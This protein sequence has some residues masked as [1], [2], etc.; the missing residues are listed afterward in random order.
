M[1]PIVRMLSLDSKKILLISPEA[2]GINHVSKH[3]YAKE[4]AKLGNEVYFLNPPSA[5]F[6]LT[7]I[8]KGLFV[9]DYKS[10]FRGLSKLPHFLSAL[11]IKYQIQKIEKKL[12]VNVEIIWNFDSSRFFNLSMLTQKLRICHIV[13]MAENIQRPLL[14]QTSD[15][16][17][18]TSDYIKK[19]LSCYS[20]N[21]TKIH[22]GY[23]IPEKFYEINEEFDKGRI[24][25]GYVGNLART[26]ID[27]ELIM[28]LIKKHL[29]V[30][31]N[32]IGS[33]EVS[34]LSKSSIDEHRLAVLKDSSNVTLLGLKESHLIPSY[35]REFDVL[36][37]AYKLENEVDI[38]QHSNLHKTM[39]Y[40][41]SG[42]VTVSTYSDEYK[43]K[44]YL[45]EMME[46][47]NQFSDVFKKVIA[48]IDTYNSQKKQQERMRFAFCNTY[49]KQLERI[50]DVLNKYYIC[51]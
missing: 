5:K 13:D 4:L 31:F 1:K 38:K 10:L 21:V 2:W 27:W 48:N 36:I 41:G 49:S 40:I 28:Q 46:K 30:Q 3:H 51:C 9:V 35:L 20:K 37:S 32:F 39:E 16:C 12:G 25:V 34:N 43:D 8:S 50:E 29:D 44:R 17:F 24:Q 33:F 22:H 14:A 11:L 42:K 6:G 15:V 47:N 23:Q 45:F 7:K 26:C 18:C 19:E